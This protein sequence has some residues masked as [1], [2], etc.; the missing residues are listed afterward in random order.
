MHKKLVATKCC[1]RG[2]LVVNR[3]ESSFFT[4]CIPF[5]SSWVL[6]FV[7]ALPIQTDKIQNKINVARHSRKPPVSSLN[8]LTDT[9]INLIALS[10]RNTVSFRA[11]HKGHLL[12]EFFSDTSVTPASSRTNPLLTPKVPW[13]PYYDCTSIKLLYVYLSHLTRLKVPWRQG[14]WITQLGIFI[15][16]HRAWHLTGRQWM[17]AK[18]MSTVGRSQCGTGEKMHTNEPMFCFVL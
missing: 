15:S 6:Y 16:Q 7:Y 3:E 11:Q 13:A 1:Q 9:P 5:S 4:V 8:K 10:A 12:E 2:N 17:S 14:L 18:L